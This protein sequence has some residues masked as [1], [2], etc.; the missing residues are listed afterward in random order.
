MNFRS[1]NAGFASPKDIQS[2]VGSSHGVVLSGGS[3]GGVVEAAGDD[4]NIELRLR[5]KGTGGVAFGTS[6][7]SIKGIYS[8][9]STY[10]HAAIGAAR[11]VEITIASTTADIAPG[12]MISVGFTVDTPNTLSSVCALVGWRT[13]A[14]ASS[15]LTV[16]FGNIS[17][18]AT[19]TGSG[20]LHLSWIDLT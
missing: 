14:T 13:S 8:Q 4:S 1:S 11:T 15:V 6:T 18:T 17:S 7:R 19:S 5:G 3:T 12:D 20:T 2:N 9:N 16:T 10:S